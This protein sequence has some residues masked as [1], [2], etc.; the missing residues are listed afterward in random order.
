MKRKERVQTCPKSAYTP[1]QC[2]VTAQD[3]SS[4]Q[5]PQ[6]GGWTSE[7]QYIPPG[8]FD[9]YRGV[10]WP[11]SMKL[12][13][14]K[15]LF[16]DQMLTSSVVKDLGVVFSHDM[17]PSE[18]VNSICLRT[19]ST[20]TNLRAQKLLYYAH[21][22]VLLCSV[23]PLPS[24]SCKTV[25]NRQNRFLR[26]IGCR[27]EFPYRLVPF[28]D[29]KTL[30]GLNSLACRRNVQDVLFLYKVITEIIDSPSILS[31]IDFRCTSVRRSRQ[32]LGRK[33]TSRDYEFY[34]AFNRI[35]RF[36]I[37]AAPHLNVS[38]ANFNLFKGNLTSCLCDEDLPHYVVA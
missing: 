22:G 37:V 14:K 23:D 2:V 7:L 24:Y 33:S 34:S 11:N 6:I 9:R 3:A 27:L 12:N 26:L 20:I 30:L 4:E 35:Q 18:H 19:S 1:V 38:A 31:R 13:V 28:N 29:I 5:K 8:G 17:N 10:V 16:G 15:L 21:A 32:L 36:V 25:G